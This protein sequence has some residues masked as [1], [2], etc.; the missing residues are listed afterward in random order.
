MTDAEN[1]AYVMNAQSQQHFPTES[2]T[3]V[4]TTG[5][6]DAFAGAFIAKTLQAAPINETVSINKTSRIVI[7]QF[8]ARPSNL[9]SISANGKALLHINILFDK[10]I[11]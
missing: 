9:D 7:E 2:I 1:G 10:L 6:G 5:A 8:G 11:L 3:P 4:D